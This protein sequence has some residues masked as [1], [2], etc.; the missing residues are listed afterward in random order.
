MLYFVLCLDSLFLPS[1]FLSSN[2]SSFIVCF[3]HVLLLSLVSAAWNLASCLITFVLPNSTYFLLRFFRYYIFGP[4]TYYIFGSWTTVRSYTLKLILPITFGF[5]SSQT[6]K[7]NGKLLRHYLMLFLN[8]IKRTTF[9]FKYLSNWIV[10]INLSNLKTYVKK[11]TFC[12]KP[13]LRAI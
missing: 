13:G 4:Q 1:P 7:S 6:P 8:F 9:F 10:V 11:G 5:V 2:H 12:T 3:Q